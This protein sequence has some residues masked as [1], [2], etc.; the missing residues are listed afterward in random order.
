GF[1]GADKFLTPE[2]KLKGSG[3]KRVGLAGMRAPARAHT[4]IYDPSGETLIGEVR[5]AGRPPP[6]SPARPGAGDGGAFSPC[7]KAPI[8]MGYVQKAFE[9]EGTE[10]AVKV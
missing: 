1:L 4:E 6:G 8:A 10:V 9:K 2:G 3:R 7:L 5:R